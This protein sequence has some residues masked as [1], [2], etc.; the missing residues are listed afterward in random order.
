MFYLIKFFYSCLYKLFIGVKPKN[1]TV[2]QGSDSTKA[3]HHKAVGTNHMHI[4]EQQ[5][6]KVRC[7]RCL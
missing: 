7:E 2:K 6:K 1:V 3:V 5:V 4:R